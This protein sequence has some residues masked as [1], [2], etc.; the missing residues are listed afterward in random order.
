M[1]L[2]WE[3]GRIADEL[4]LS[5]HTVLN[6]VRNF[7][8]RLNTPTKLIAVATAMRLGTIRR[9]MACTWRTGVRWADG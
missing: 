4:G 7:R 6:H 3:T 5:P 9:L 8:H 1:A 2:G